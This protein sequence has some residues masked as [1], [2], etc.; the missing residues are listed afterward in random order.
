MTVLDVTRGALVGALAVLTSLP[1]SPAAA[2]PRAR[3]D[4]AAIQ[5]LPGRV[6]GQGTNREP[7]GELRLRSFVLE[8][9][10][11]PRPVQAMVDG[12]R[13]EVETAWRL[14]VTGERF[15]VRAMPA[16]LLID[17]QPVATG[18]EN[19]DLTRL[20]FLIFNKRWLRPGASLA[21]TYE[22]DLLVDARDP[23]L[24]VGEISLPAREGAQ[25]YALPETLNLDK[26]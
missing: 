13:A 12:R 7:A 21:L 3:L 22:G 24:V 18:I 25:V 2:A 26:E 19:S 14:T 17:D 4:L 11:L 23:E 1:S 10:A 16:V 20:S 9:V 15:P 8:E 5:E 6:I